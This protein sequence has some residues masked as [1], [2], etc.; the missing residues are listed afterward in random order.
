MLFLCET[1]TSPRPHPASHAEYPRWEA[2]WGRGL[3]P[4]F[5]QNCGY[6]ASIGPNGA[7]PKMW[8]WRWGTSWPARLPTLLSTR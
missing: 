8:T 1:R 7:P 4:H 5:K 6:F 3:A 2:G